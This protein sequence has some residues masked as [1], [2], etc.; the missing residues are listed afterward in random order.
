[1]CP[2]PYYDMIRHNESPEYLRLKMVQYAKAHGIRVACR[3]FNVHRDTMRKWFYRFDGSLESLKDESR[4]PQSCP[5]KINPELEKEIVHLKKRLPTWGAERLKRDFTLPCSAKA[6]GRVYRQN[7]LTRKRRRKHTVK[8]DLREVKRQWRLFQQIDVDT[9]DLYDIPEYWPAM[10]DLG[11]PRVQYSAREVVSGLTFLAYAQEK[12]LTYATLFIHRILTHLKECGIDLKEV[13]FQ[14]DNGSEFIGSW[15]AKEKSSFSKMIE[16]Q[17]GASHQT[18]PP[19]AHTY[20]ADVETIHRLIEDE[21]F[22]IEK[23]SSRRDFLAKVSTYQIFF[24]VART[25]SYKNH[26]TPLQILQERNPSLDPRIVLLHPIF[27]ED[28]LESSVPDT[29]PLISQK[30]YHVPSYP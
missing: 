6:I 7:G 28:L 20:Q 5:H 2:I 29:L 9:K 19:A 23:F 13:A 17:N 21:L 8:N 1:M 25:N 10:M 4:A 14:S 15:N 27:L 3:A 11:L 24:N 22:I 30:G 26:K 16:D 18:I 12:N